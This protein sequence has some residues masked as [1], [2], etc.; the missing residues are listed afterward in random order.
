MRPTAAMPA[1]DRGYSDGD[2]QRASRDTLLSAA[3]LG[4]SGLTETIAADEALYALIT[5]TTAASTDIAI[6]GL[7]LTLTQN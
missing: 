1:A 5:A 3:N 7:L 2:A 4:V 6:M